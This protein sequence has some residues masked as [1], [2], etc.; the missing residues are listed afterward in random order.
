M[1][2]VKKS[3]RRLSRGTRVRRKKH[4]YRYKKTQRNTRKKKRSQR[5][6]GDDGAGGGAGRRQCSESEELLCFICCAGSTE[7]DE[8]LRVGCACRGTTPTA[9]AHVGCVA[10]W[11]QRFGRADVWTNCSICGIRYTGQFNLQLAKNRMVQT[12]SLAAISNYGTAL[13]DVGELATAETELRRA[14]T[15]AEQHPEN[16]Q[17]ILGAKNNLANLLK[18]RGNLD[19]AEK[20][21]SQALELSTRVWGD[22]DMKSIVASSNLAMMKH[23]RAKLLA[24][25]GEFDGALAKFNHAERMLKLAITKITQIEETQG[26]DHQNDL[27]KLSGSLAMIMNDHAKI[28]KDDTKFSDAETKLKSV[29]EW[30]ITNLGGD[31]PDTNLAV[32]NL[33]VLLVDQ[34][35]LLV[36][37]TRFDEADA[38]FAEAEA[39]LDQAMTVR[40]NTLGKSHP[41][42]LKSVSNLA[43]IR[44]RIADR[45]K[46]QDK[47]TEAE[48]IIRKA[49]EMCNEF[50]GPDDKSTLSLMIKLGSLLKAKGQPSDNDEGNRILAQCQERTE[51]LIQAP[52]N[53]EDMGYMRRILQDAKAASQ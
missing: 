1:V 22:T 33:G 3:S 14:L 34:G 21:Y 9:F 45:M 26:G 37:Q 35:N 52:S 42:T 39:M 5:G 8:V 16:H 6:G 2:R 31:H 53:P 27:M 43:A 41:A 25:R 49:L 23:R 11:A 13:Q 32:S 15:Q 48:E 10:E 18:I 46:G 36:D 4:V 51:A 44:T 29:V 17:G 30:M 40:V 19:D 50:L 24:D 12:P 47:I 38:K 20:M 28:L 7:D